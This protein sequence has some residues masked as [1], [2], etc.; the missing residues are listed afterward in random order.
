MK[1]FERFKIF[2][3]RKTT[4]NIYQ[5]LSNIEINPQERLKIRTLN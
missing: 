3:I 4:Q 2:I 5:I 1:S